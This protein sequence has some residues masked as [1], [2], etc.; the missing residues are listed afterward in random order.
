MKRFALITAVLGSALALVPF[1]SAQ[2]L[3]EAGGGGV[4]AA[5]V[6]PSVD[7]ATQ[8]VLLR[9][10]A[11][12]NEYQTQAA[13]QAIIQR[14]QGLANYYLDPATR[15]VLLRS[16]GLAHYFQSNGYTFHTDVLGG[17][18][19]SSTGALAT[20]SDTFDWNTTLAVTLGGMLL[21]ALAATMITRR[22]HQHQPSF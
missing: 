12:A 6:S 16:K 21:I 4:G 18:G 17:Q 8:A 5:A 14:S 9:S 11:L 19:G 1:A 15:A 20:T 2:V 7:P 22:R 3:S 13:N 10:H